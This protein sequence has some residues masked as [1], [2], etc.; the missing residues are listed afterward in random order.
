MDSLGFNKFST[1]PCNCTNKDLGGTVLRLQSNIKGKSEKFFDANSSHDYKIEISTMDITDKTL[2]IILSDF[3]AFK[4]IINNH[5]KE[6]LEII[7]LV[8]HGNVDSAASIAQKIGL[9]E[10][11][12]VKRGGGIAWFAVA[13][14]FALVL[15]TPKP[16][17]EFSQRPPATTQEFNEIPDHMSD[18]E[19]DDLDAAVGASND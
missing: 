18:E 19:V 1:E 13:G 8:Q 14:V 10:D 15:L 4:S 16:I 5:R 2:D 3:E 6:I 11:E 17:S 12:L 9:T 7:H